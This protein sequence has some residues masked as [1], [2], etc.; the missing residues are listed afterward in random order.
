MTV[1]DGAAFFTVIG[2][3]DFFTVLVGIVVVT[4][5]VVWATVEID[6]GFVVVVVVELVTVAALQINKNGAK[7]GITVKNF[8]AI[9]APQCAQNNK[10]AQINGSYCTAQHSTHWMLIFFFCFFLPIHFAQFY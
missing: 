8:I 6:L 10:N 3:R 5:S 1:E 7:N 4:V 9:E 2:G